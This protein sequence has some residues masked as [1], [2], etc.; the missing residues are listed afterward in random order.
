MNQLSNY[1]FYLENR[2]KY[3]KYVV[4]N[5]S[6]LLSKFIGNRFFAGCLLILFHINSVLFVLYNL[7][8]RI[9][10]IDKLVLSIIY[11]MIYFFYFLDQRLSMVIVLCK[12][13]Y[14]NIVC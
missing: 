1:I 11:F 13:Q 5:T 9:I 12:Q 6:N 4:E 8:L 3:T 2:K 14:Y 7:K 10:L